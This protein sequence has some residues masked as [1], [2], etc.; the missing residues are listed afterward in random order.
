MTSK[1]LPS[2]LTFAGPFPKLARRL[3]LGIVGG[4]RISVT[5]SSAARLSDYWE[6]CAGALS[7]DPVKAKQKGQQWYLDEDRCYS[8]FSEMAEKESQRED[9][10]DAVMITTPNHLHY[11]AAKAFLE[12][13]IHVLCDKPLTNEIDQAMDLMRL[14]QQTGLVFGVSFVNTAFP[15]I[16][17]AKAM[18]EKGYIGKINQVHVEFMQDWMMNEDIS[19]A[20]HVK[21][22]LDPKKSGSTS[23]TGD[24]GTHA[25]NLANFV[26]GLEMTDILAQMHVCGAP[27]QLED[28]VIMM[29]KY[30]GAIPGTLMATRLAS[31]NRGGLRLRVFGDQGGLEWDM[32]YPERL[33]YSK[34]GDADKV[35]TR[36][37]GGELFPEVERLTR[38][39]RGFSEGA[40][41]AWANLYT[42]F[43]LAVAAHKDGLDTPADWLQFPRV[44][45]GAKGVRFSDA[46]VESHNQNGAWVNCTL[47]Q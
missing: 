40:L 33:K 39:A 3:R 46:T 1:L 34:F 31:G 47:N 35:L 30:D 44:E 26:T 24:I 9:G 27:K 6:I 29:T 14:T 37:Q 17:Q 38:L 21:W 2:D 42:E 16:R 5:Q 41:E 45:A 4:G 15:M 8:S 19:Q 36:G 7:S 43:A 32:E 25:Q 20:E 22:R 28:T 10:V 18:V 12:V 11:D 13:G 23:C